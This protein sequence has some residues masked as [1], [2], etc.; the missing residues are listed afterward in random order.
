MKDTEF[1]CG[2]YV[3]RC[4]DWYVTDREFL[5]RDWYVKDTEFVAKLVYEGYKINFKKKFNN[6]FK[7][8]LKP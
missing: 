7:N 4:K 3:I 8:K 6:H 1:R 2:E 5:C